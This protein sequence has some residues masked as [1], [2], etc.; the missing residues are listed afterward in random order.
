MR[1]ILCPFCQWIAA[2]CLDDGTRPSGWAA[3]HLAGCPNCQAR[4]ERDQGIADRLAVKPGDA[5]LEMP[6]FLRE[7]ILANLDS[8]RSS[9][10]S[11]PVFRVAAWTGAIL[12]GAAVLVLVTLLLKDAKGVESRLELSVPVATVAPGGSGSGTDGH[13]H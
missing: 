6:A 5:P 11:A 9:S 1:S 2:R 3:R 13:K 8:R 12:G 7:R 10:E 4:H